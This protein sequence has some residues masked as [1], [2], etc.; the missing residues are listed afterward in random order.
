MYEHVYGSHSVLAFLLHDVFGVLQHL[1][2]PQVKEVGWIG[3]K[4]EGL[5][6]II[7]VDNNLFKIT[8]LTSGCYFY[9]IKCLPHVSMR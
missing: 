4:L 3:V 7:P 9:Y 6:S 8:P 2:F 5:L 1:L